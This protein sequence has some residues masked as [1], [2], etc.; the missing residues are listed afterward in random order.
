MG[1]TRNSYSAGTK[2]VDAC[3]LHAAAH[4]ASNACIHYKLFVSH[5]VLHHMYIAH[6]LKTIKIYVYGCSLG[7]QMIG[8]MLCQFRNFGSFLEICLDDSF[9]ISFLLATV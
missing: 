3:T 9:L 8:K 4:A 2:T 1:P 7:C 6:F 5:Y